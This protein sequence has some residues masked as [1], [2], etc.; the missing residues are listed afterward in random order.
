MEQT[1]PKLS[2][3]CGARGLSR[4]LTGEALSRLGKLHTLEIGT[5][6]MTISSIEML[7]LQI[8][9]QLTNT[10]TPLKKTQETF[11]LSNMAAKHIYLFFPS[12]IHQKNNHKQNKPD[13]LSVDGFNCGMNQLTKSLTHRWE[14]HQIIVR[15][16]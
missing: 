11:S 4:G 1:S 3:G 13:S 15:K 2:A 9:D 5:G 16:T 7:Y 8:Q 6:F 10:I 12:S 14:R